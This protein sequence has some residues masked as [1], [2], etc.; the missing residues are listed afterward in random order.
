MNILIINQ[1]LNN[2]GDESA[3]KGLVRALVNAIPD[4]NIRVLFRDKG[5]GNSIDQYN[6]HLPNVEYVKVR[7]HIGTQLA[8][9]ALKYRIYRLWSLHPTTRMELANFRWADWVICAP[10]GI[11]MGG[12]QNWGHLCFLHMA[13]YTNKPL[14]Y[15]G[16]SF[17][18]FPT[19][20][21][22]NRLFKKLSL[23]ML[24]YFSFLSIRD[25]KTENLAKEI[26]VK[27]VSTV[28]SAFLDSSQA[29]LDNQLIEKI[30]SDKYVVFVPNLLVWH[31][32]YKQ[33]TTKQDVLV[34]FSRILEKYK[35][36]YPKHKVVMLPQTFNNG[37]YEL[38]DIN[39]F[40][41]L[42]EFTHDDDIVIFDDNLSSD[43][44]QAIIHK[45]AFVVGARYHSIVFAINQNVPFVALSYEHKIAGLLETLGKQSNMIDITHTFDN[46]GNMHKSIDDF[47]R[48][49]G[50]VQFDPDL[51]KKAKDIARNCFCEFAKMLNK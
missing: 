51:Q 20:T 40:K 14:A 28:D 4:C 15:Y 45:S 37:T 8:I 22:S 43:I 19:I 12:F 39:F 32:H 36:A 31:Y 17:G 25:R 33:I 30:G 2:R 26:G 21:N 34:F 47:S 29:L 50:I 13:K 41:E 23:E 46:A 18:P 5:N 1:P 3:H 10:G 48:L 11:C 38:D 42:K 44:Q 24:D 9:Y 35:E 49:I 6:V 7:K 27:Y 16:R